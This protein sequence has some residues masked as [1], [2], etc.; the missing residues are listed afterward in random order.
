MRFDQWSANKVDLSPLERVESVF[1][2]FHLFASDKSKI[3][4]V[5]ALAADF[6]GLAKEIQFEMNA[7]VDKWLTW[8]AAQIEEGQAARQIRSDF[9]PRQLAE[10][11]YNMGMGSQFQ[12]RIRG[13]PGLTTFSGKAMVRFLHG[14]S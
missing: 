2:I 11:V 10:I 13:L 8:L 4:P 7:F 9:K 1:E 12:A 5:L 6:Q 14:D 3:C